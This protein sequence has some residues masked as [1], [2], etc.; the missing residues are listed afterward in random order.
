MEEVHGLVCAAAA[1]APALAATVVRSQEKPQRSIG[2]GRACQVLARASLEQWVREN[3]DIRFPVW[4]IQGAAYI[5][6]GSA[7]IYR[8]GSPAVTP[9]ARWAI[10]MK[11]GAEC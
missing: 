1:A 7:T 10:P 6:V 2:D 4:P 9:G 8:F 11:S 5:K 3:P